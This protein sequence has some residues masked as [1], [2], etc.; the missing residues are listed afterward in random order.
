MKK[1][2]LL[3]LAISC[4]SLLKA[5]QKIRDSLE[6]FDNVHFQEHASSIKDDL[7]R[8]RYAQSVKRNF[9]KNKYNLI[10]ATPIVSRGVSTST[11]GN[12]DFEDGNANGWTMTGDYQVMSGSGTD[13]FGGFPVVCPGGNFSLRLNDNNTNAASCSPPGP[14]NTFTSTATKSLT[15]TSAN[16]LVKVN[17]AACFLE[18]P[19]T[20]TDAAS[21]R[22]E[23]FDALNNPLAV[24][25][26]TTK[27]V[28]PGGGIV[29]SMPVANASTTITGLQVCGYGNY[30]VSYLP[31]QQKQF[32][33]SAY[34][35]Q[36]IQIKL[37]A[38]WCLYQYDFG[39]AYFDVCCDNICPYIGP[40]SQTKNYYVCTTT[41]FS[42]TACTNNPF[43][44]NFQWYDS[45]GPISTASCIPVSAY[46]NYTLT[47]NHPSSPTFTINEV[48]TYTNAAAISFSLPS[49][50]C[51]SSTV[52]LSATPSGGTF[53]GPG[54]SGNSFIANTVGTK[55]ITYTYTNTA[56]CSSALSQTVSVIVCATGIQEQN[57]AIELA[58]APNP[59]R[60]EI[61]VWCKGTPENCE[62]ILFNTLGQEI[63]RKKLSDGKNSIETDALPSGL[64]IYSLLSQNKQVKQ[65]KLV[66]E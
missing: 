41:P 35:G 29:A 5:Q 2:I 28:N 22:V 7:A 19:H 15:I 25:T 49:T 40:T 32:N 66:K 47:S 36:T 23:F 33:L 60:N 16:S 13:P 51:K 52:A 3:V 1:N 54:V 26:F 42:L 45:S 50:V 12:F 6:G 59:F 8:E 55:T 17:F 24:P 37:S 53:S 61:S 48:F 63:L 14:K 65:G 57:N 64:Y 4:F 62:F 43:N 27:Y 44:T 46:G 10:P 21:V 38:G 39:Y 18:F 20:Q 34:I 30:G 11:C 58:V 31:W 9:I 56:G